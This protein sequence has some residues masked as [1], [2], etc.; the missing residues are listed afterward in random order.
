LQRDVKKPED[1][2]EFKAGIQLDADGNIEIKTGD[3]V[4]ITYKDGEIAIKCDGGPIKITCDE[5][6][7]DGKLTA[8]GD[9]KLKGTL[10]VGTG[11]GVTIDG[12]EITGG[13]V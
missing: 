11:T 8:T 10:K 7:V 2:S 12:T 5:L 4:V 13:P 6:T 1:N 9:A 3:K